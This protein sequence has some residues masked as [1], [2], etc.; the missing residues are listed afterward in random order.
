MPE[1]RIKKRALDAILLRYGIEWDTRQGKGSHGCYV[2]VIQ[3]RK[4]KFPLPRAQE[5]PIQYMRS[6]R[7]KFKLLPEHGIADEEFYGD[8]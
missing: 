2:G 3:G 8:Q 6:L 7:R 5:V 1:R 4:Q